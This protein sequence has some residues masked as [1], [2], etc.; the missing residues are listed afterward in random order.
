ME[1]LHQRLDPHAEVRDIVKKNVKDTLQYIPYEEKLQ[2][3]ETFPILD[4]EPEITL[5]WGDK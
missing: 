3:V 2:N 5:D 4:E 1:S